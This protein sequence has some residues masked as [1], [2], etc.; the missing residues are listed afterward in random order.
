MDFLVWRWQSSGG[1]NYNYFDVTT[2]LQVGQVFA[3]VNTNTIAVNSAEWSKTP[4]KG[5][6]IVTFDNASGEDEAQLI[7]VTVK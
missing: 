5:L 3:A 2:N 6:M 4:A 1:T 7:D